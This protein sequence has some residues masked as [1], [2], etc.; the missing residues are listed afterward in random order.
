M[1]LDREEKPPTPTVVSPLT[2]TLHPFPSGV[3]CVYHGS[4]WCRR[5]QPWQRWWYRSQY[6]TTCYRND[7][8]SARTLHTPRHGRSR[9]KFNHHLFQRRHCRLNL[10]Y[11]SQVRV[12]VQHHLKHEYEYQ[13]D[14]VDEPDRY[15]GGR[16]D[17][18]GVYGCEDDGDA[19]CRFVWRRGSYQPCRDQQ[20]VS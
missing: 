6:P 13:C 3:I 20:S 18:A 7:D 9:D 4:S 17:Y 1:C 5:F 10:I 15:S 2:I 16:E 8:G 12:R 14:Q 11:H 19:S